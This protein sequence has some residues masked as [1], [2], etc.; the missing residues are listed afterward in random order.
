[1]GGRADVFMLFPKAWTLKET[2]TGSSSIRTRVVDSIFFGN[3]YYVKQ[4]SH[5]DC[6]CSNNI[7]AVFPSGNLS[8]VWKI[9][10]E[11]SAEEKASIKTMQEGSKEVINCKDKDI[12]MYILI[13]S[14]RTRVEYNTKSIISGLNL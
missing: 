5:L 6:Y 3:N 7:S 10:W 2:L 14:L 8:L 11:V 1:M 12:I 4:A 13:H 9:F